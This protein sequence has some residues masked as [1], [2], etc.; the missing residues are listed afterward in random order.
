VNGTEQ[1][2]MTFTVTASDPDG[3][4]VASLTADLSALPAGNNAAF[5]VGA[6]NTSGTFTWT[7]VTGNSRPAPYNVTFTALNASTSSATSAITVLLPNQNPTAALALSPVTGNAPLVVTANAGASTDPDG[8]IVSYRFD[9]GDGTIVGPQAGSTATHSYAAGNWTASLLVTD[10]GGG[11]ATA[12]ASVFAAS[13]GPGPNLVGNPSFE[14]STTGWS[15]SSGVIQRVAGGFDGTSSLQMQG[16]STGTP[17]FGV[18]DSPNWVLAPTTAGTRYRLTAWVRSATAVGKAFLRIR[19]YLGSVQ[20]GITSESP[21][22]TLSP[23][24]QMVTFDYVVLTSGSTLDF[25]VLDGPVVPNEVFQTDNISIRVVTGGAAA[26][27]VT[28][29]GA[30]VMPFTAVMAP[31]P[32]NPTSMLLFTTTRDGSV[33][34]RIFDAS[35][36]RVRDLLE[37]ARVPAGRHSVQFDG[38]DAAGRRLASGVYFYRVEASEGSIQGRMVV[39]K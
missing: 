1:V 27:L 22:V 33:H 28:G 14:S 34:V 17:K 7:P 25:Q 2:P 38:L 31:N 39:M 9:F 32:M 26:S 10:N 8:F 29:R 6:G 20:Q 37:M 30:P 12:T 36:R 24:W 18:N 4:A 5:T 16:P 15:A 3:D 19:E 21:L 23:A 35:G 13:V 11:T